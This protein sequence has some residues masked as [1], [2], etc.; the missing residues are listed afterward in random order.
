LPARV[1][2][3]GSSAFSEIQWFGGA[4]AAAGLTSWWIVDAEDHQLGAGFL[5]AVHAGVLLNNLELSVEFL[6]FSHVP[7]RIKNDSFST[8]S[9]FGI[10]LQC[11][12]FFPLSSRIFSPLRVGIGASLF[13]V[14]DVYADQPVMVTTKL[15]LI[16]IAYKWQKWLFEATLPSIRYNTNASDSHLVSWLPQLRISYLF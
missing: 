13:G 9:V 1:S 3:G 5:A 7:I 14:H 15:D 11:G 4:S 10:G 16:G 12:Y 2:A 8:G 6:P